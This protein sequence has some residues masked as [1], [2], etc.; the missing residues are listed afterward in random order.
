MANNE[1]DV[2]KKQ[3]FDLCFTHNKLAMKLDRLQKLFPA[4]EETVKLFDNTENVNLL[5]Q[6]IDFQYRVMAE[7]MTLFNLSVDFITKFEV[8]FGFKREERKTK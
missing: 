5:K 7:C 4:W 3:F 6:Q 2:K 8:Y 1:N